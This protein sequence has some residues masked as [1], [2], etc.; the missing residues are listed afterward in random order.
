MLIRVEEEESASREVEILLKVKVEGAFSSTPLINIFHNVT[1]RW[2]TFT[3]QMAAKLSSLDCQYILKMVL[4]NIWFLHKKNIQAFVHTN[5]RGGG[6][7]TTPSDHFCKKYL[8]P[9][10]EIL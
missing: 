4:E 5:C 9:E 7:T 1:H 6:L 2:K 8:I 3:A 10:F